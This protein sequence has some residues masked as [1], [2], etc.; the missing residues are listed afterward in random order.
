[1]GM[2]LS[3]L[4]VTPATAFGYVFYRETN[5]LETFFVLVFSLGLA[6]ANFTMYTP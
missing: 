4:G 2:F 1:M 6:G 5:A 3:L